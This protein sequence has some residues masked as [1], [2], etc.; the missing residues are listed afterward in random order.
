MVST[1]NDIENALIN[2]NMLAAEH[3]KLSTYNRHVVQSQKIC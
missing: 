1:L 3:V 2:S